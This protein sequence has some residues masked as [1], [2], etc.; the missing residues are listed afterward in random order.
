MDL[1]HC[2]TPRKSNF[3]KKG[4]NGNFGQ[5]PEFFKISDDETD[6]IVG[7]SREIYLLC[8]I[9]LNSEIVEISRFSRHVEEYGTLGTL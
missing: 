3:M 8:R 9:S 6:I 5:D 7:S 2:E 4:R 1:L